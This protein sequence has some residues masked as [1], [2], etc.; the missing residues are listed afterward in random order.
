MSIL[1]WKSLLARNS[2]FNDNF[3]QCSRDDISDKLK[4][5]LSEANAVHISNPKALEF[6]VRVV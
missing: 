3:L 5:P 6:Q 2:K 1:M 4:K